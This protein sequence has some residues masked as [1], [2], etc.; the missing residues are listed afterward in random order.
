MLNVHLLTA[1][2]SLSLIVLDIV[3]TANL[4]IVMSTN[5]AMKRVARENIINIISNYLNIM[6]ILSHLKIM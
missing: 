3:I 5:L 6:P 1:F 4:S 2:A